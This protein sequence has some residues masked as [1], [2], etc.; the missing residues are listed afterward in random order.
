MNYT[1]KEKS[2]VISLL[3]FDHKKQ[4]KL[5]NPKVI[6]NRFMLLLDI[7]KKSHLERKLIKSIK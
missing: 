7:V 2:E 5:L 6:D 3:E 4:S 1:I